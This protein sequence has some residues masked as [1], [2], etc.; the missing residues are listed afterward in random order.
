MTRSEALED[1][2]FY[3]QRGTEYLHVKDVSIFALI[4]KIFDDFGEILQDKDAEITL[5]KHCV[6]EAIK[7][8]MGVEPSVWSD[9][10]MGKPL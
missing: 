5:L 4:H 7:R 1:V 9:Y 2:H 6:E 8:P 3:R 10:K